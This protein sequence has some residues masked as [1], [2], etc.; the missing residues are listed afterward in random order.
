[1]YTIDDL[2]VRLLSELK[3]IAENSFHLTPKK[4]KSEIKKCSQKNCPI[5]VINLKPMYRAEIV[6]QIRASEIENLEILEVGRVY[7]F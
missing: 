3:D 1:M 2:N 4:L 6:E 5:Y 7:N